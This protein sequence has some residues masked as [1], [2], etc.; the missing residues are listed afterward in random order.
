MPT[1][2][3]V[4]VMKSTSHNIKTSC[5]ILYGSRCYQNGS[6]CQD[7]DGILWKFCHIWPG[8]LAV[9]PLFLVELVPFS[10]NGCVSSHKYQIGMESGE[11]GGQF[12]A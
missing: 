11:F 2:H 5:L 6:T 9:D 10:I 12:K 1:K 8:I 4:A 7:M 3:T